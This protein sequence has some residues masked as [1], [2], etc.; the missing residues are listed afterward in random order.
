MS[1][2]AA[3]DEALAEVPPAD[4]VRAAAV[5]LVALVADGLGLDEDELN[6]AARRGLLLAA[7]EG[8]PAASCGL[9]SRAAA[10]TAAD[11]AADGAWERLDA[12]LVGLAAG[13]AGLPRAAVA[14]DDLRDDRALALEALAVIVL[15]Q[16]LA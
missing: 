14:I 10:E 1:D 3:I 12:L 15:H 9:G 5:V 7:A 8:D 6:G 2:L 16:A 4:R 13:A 11:L